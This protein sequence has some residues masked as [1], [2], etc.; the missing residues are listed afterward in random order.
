MK[1]RMNHSCV[2]SGRYPSGVDGVCLLEEVAELR[3]SVAADAGNRSATAGVLLDEVVD[4]VMS[5]TGFEIEHVVR[6]P[7]L[8][9][10]SPRIVHGIEGAARAVRDILTVTEQLHRRANDVVALLDEQ[11]RGD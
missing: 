3:E 2:V 5:E 6:D 11:R 10:D 7:E 1:L 9:A 4:H 8:L